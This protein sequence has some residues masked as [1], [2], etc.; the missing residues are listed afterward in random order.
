ML[1][2]TSLFCDYISPKNTDPKYYKEFINK[3]TLFTVPIIYS[4]AVLTPDS[5]VGLTKELLDTEVN[6]FI[7]DL[8]GNA[9]ARRSLYRPLCLAGG[10]DPG[11][12]V[13]DGEKRTFVSH[14][15]EETSDR[16]SL[17]NRELIL[18]S[19]NASAFL[20][21]FSLLEDTLKKIYWQI[22][23]HK[24]DK[25]L[26]T[27]GETISFYLKNILS[28]KNIENEF[29]Y[30]IEQ[31]SKF[32]N[33]FEALVEMWSLMNLIRNKYIHNGNYYN[34]RSREFFNQR[35]FSVISKFSRDEYSLEKVLFI[36]KFDPMINEIKETGQLTFSDTLENCIRNIGLFVMESL[37][38]CDRKSKQENRK[39]KHVRSF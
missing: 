23:H 35:V 25:T 38:L 28:L 2:L 6:Q 8:P 18:S 14:F 27:G 24:K 21:Y 29:I 3:Y 13:Q 17:S 30:Q 15:F 33:N 9:T 26:R 31:R 4:Q 7:N 39:K 20:N 16:L 34:K 5:S 19:L 36:D 1:P 12:M 11:K 22:S 37:L 10:I 32:F